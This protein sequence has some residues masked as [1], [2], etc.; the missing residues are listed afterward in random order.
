VVSA[1]RS[2][3][4]QSSSATAGDRR[5]RVGRRA[6]RDR[7]EEPC[8]PDG[9]PGAGAQDRGHLCTT[10]ARARAFAF[11]S[12]TTRAIRHDPAR[13][14]AGRRAVADGSD[15]GAARSELGASAMRCSAFARAYADGDETAYPAARR[16][17]RAPDARR[18]ARRR[19]GGFGAF[20]GAE[21]PLRA[22][23]A[24][25]REDLAGARMAIAL[26]LREGTRV[27]VTSRQP[28]GDHQSSL[29]AIQHEAD[30]QGSR[31]AA[32]RRR[33]TIRTTPSRIAASSSSAVA[34]VC[35][36]I[37]HSTSWRGRRG[38]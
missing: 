12:T 33:V 5:A 2:S 32:S 18:S 14:L 26:M 27:G 21:L 19:S 37:R 9:L 4:T 31:S 3:T 13:H 6:A 17:A 36:R 20:S 11:G 23:A 10:P 25:I 29:R 35:V 30:A 1:G 34:D 16:V 15:S 24:G 8:L 38:R 22:G 7:G 28:Q